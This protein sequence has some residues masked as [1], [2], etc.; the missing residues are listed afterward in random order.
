VHHASVNV[1]QAVSVTIRDR[2]VT[3]E[4]SPD[5][6]APAVP[7]KRR[8]GALKARKAVAHLRVVV[9]AT[10]VLG[11]GL[12]GVQAPANAAEPR[13]DAPAALAVHPTP[14]NYNGAANQ[15]MPQAMAVVRAQSWVGVTPYSQFNCYTN[16]YGDFRTDCS[17]LIAMAW[18]L[19]G[20]GD[21]W[22]TGNLGS[23]STRISASQLEAGDALLYHD[24]TSNGSHV[25][26]FVRWDD[27]ARSRPV[28]IQETG[29]AGNTIQGVPSNFNWRNYVPI[30]YNNIVPTGP[31][32]TAAVHY[33][34]VPRFFARGLDGQLIQY[35][36]QADGSW[37]VEGRGGSI[38][39]TPGAVVDGSVL[40]VF[41]SGVDGTPWQ[42]WF[43]GTW[44]LTA[45][46]NGKIASGT[47]AVQYR[48]VPRFFARGL[49]GQLI[50]Y[51][52]RADG[53]WD[54][55]ALGGNFVGTPGAVVD[56]SDLRVF[57]RGADGSPWQY[58]Y[59]WYDGTWHLGKVD[60]GQITSGIGA[61][62]FWDVPRFF[63]RGLDGQLIQYFRQANG[64]WAWEGLGG[65]ILGTPGV[66]LDGSVLRVFVSGADGTPWQY[67]FDGTW[68]K[69]SL[70]IGKIT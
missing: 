40:R 50:Q 23:V 9:I 38:L 56:G 46:N 64:S 16:A 31:A 57:V 25:A 65:S 54:W 17:G 37:G 22:W 6:P 5:R 47:A 41:A 26:M 15:A 13:P 55:Q 7:E 36:R 33:W 1:G 61:V 69:A 21:S 18:G 59:N 67:W 24:G 52:M 63:A 70:G 68:N 39:G 27:V 45:I 14:C 11:A 34:G 2:E 43:D 8:L 49:D 51:F 30:R 29:S 62:Y 44:H 10:A 12:L 35:F 58:W 66:V 53:S 32:G 20:R 42:Y 3:M 28:V 19:G 60:N 48:G 4:L